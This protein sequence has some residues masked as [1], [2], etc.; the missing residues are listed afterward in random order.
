[1]IK[2]LDLQGN[3]LVE[4]KNFDLG[5]KV[6][7]AK[8]EISDFS[9][10]QIDNDV[11]TVSMVKVKKNTFVRNDKN[12]LVPISRAYILNSL[13]GEPIYIYKTLKGKVH[14]T[15]KIKIIYK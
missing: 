8:F 6:A 10:I 13:I 4:D 12:K 3:V 1:M 11:F 14:Q 9:K 15:K 7:F 2:I 5:L